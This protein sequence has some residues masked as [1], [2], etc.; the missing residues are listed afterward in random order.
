LRIVALDPKLVSERTP[1][2]REL[3]E[4][5]RAMLLVVDQVLL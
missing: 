5:G 4:V 1:N 3:L 2:R